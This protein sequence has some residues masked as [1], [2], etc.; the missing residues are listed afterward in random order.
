ML[1]CSFHLSPAHMHML[2]LYPF[3]Q[4][5]QEIYSH[6]FCELVILTEEVGVG[7]ESTVSWSAQMSTILSICLHLSLLPSLVHRTSVRLSSWAN[8]QTQIHQSVADQG[9]DQNPFALGN[10]WYDKRSFFFFYFLIGLPTCISC[11]LAQC[12]GIHCLSIWLGMP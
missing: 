5:P 6:K 4:V 10:S 2:I 1:S 7:N 11:G 9:N 12:E 8:L 3:L